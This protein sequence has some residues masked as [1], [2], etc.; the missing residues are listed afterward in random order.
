MN[1]RNSGASHKE[2][3]ATDVNDMTEADR[4]GGDGAGTRADGAPAG[5]ADESGAAEIPFADPTLQDLSRE[6]LE[7]R[8]TTAAAELERLQDQSLRRQA[9]LANF[10]RRVQKEQAELSAVAQARLLAGL[11]PVIDDFERA[12]EAESADV[13]TY[14]EGVEAILRGVHKVLEQIGVQRFEPRDEA[15]DPRYHEA[16]ARQETDEVPEGQILDVFQ[17]G[18]RL[19]ERL[20]RPATVV[21]AYGAAGSAAQDG[22]ESAEEAVGSGSDDSAADE[23]TRFDN[24]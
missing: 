3:E 23:T 22:E 13:D 17:P 21:V 4:R 5:D 7:A 16:I 24:V 12:V 11:V 6:E 9:E 8:L 19:G 20:I 18:Y 10:R 15:F 2:T 1:E 14:R